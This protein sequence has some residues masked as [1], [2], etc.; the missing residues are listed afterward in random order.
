M[1]SKPGATLHVVILGGFAALNSYRLVATPTHPASYPG[2]AA[3]FEQGFVELHSLPCD[4]FLG[5][6]GSYFDMQAKLKRLPSEG[7]SI[8]IDP[9]GLSPGPSPTPSMTSSSTS[10]VS[11]APTRHGKPCDPI[12]AAHQQVLR[13]PIAKLISALMPPWLPI[14]ALSYLLGSIPFGYLLVP[15]LPPPGHPHPRQRQY[16]RHQR[17][18]LRRPRPRPRHPSPSTASKAPS[19]S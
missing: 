9:Q 5:A 12:P 19:L 16:R 10:R 3:D 17:P 7:P 14:A 13:F 1:S 15:R 8:W 2:I 11:A 4:I 6:H 18:P